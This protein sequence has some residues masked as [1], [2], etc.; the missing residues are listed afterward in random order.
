MQSTIAEGVGL[1][2][3]YEKQIRRDE[4]AIA[5]T[6]GAT[7]AMYA[8]RRSLWR[9]LP[10]DT[11]LDDVLAP[12]RCVLA[13]SRVVFDDRARAYDCAARNAKDEIR[14]KR[15][16]LA[17]NYQLFW[18]EPA[19][20]LPWRNPA[21]I[22]FVSHKV[23]RLA[24]PYALPPLWLLSVLL[25]RR[26]MVY[27]AAFAAQCLFYLL[28]TYGAWLEKHEAGTTRDPWARPPVAVPERLAR[29]ALMVLVMNASAVAGLA[30]LLTRQKV[31]R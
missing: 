4:S 8:M 9:P 10:E 21:W 22:Q 1:Y 11:I 2:W 31:W 6:M 16:T 18:L 27:A 20:L 12:M 28:A 23:A 25:S 14:R 3:R 24:V 26:S 17:G 30:A 29:V 19:L 13:G 7:G 15:R 5:S